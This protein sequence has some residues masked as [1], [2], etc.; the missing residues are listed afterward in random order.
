MKRPIICCILVILTGQSWCS[1]EAAVTIYQ[2]K[3]EVAFAILAGGRSNRMGSNKA[4]LVLK[5]RRFVDI[6]IDKAKEAGFQS[7]SVSGHD[8]QNKEVDFVSDQ[9]TDRGPLG[10][11]HAV[12]KQCNQEMSF[13]ISVDVP[14]IQCRT[15]RDIVE[16]HKKS[17]CPVTL[18]RHNEKVEPLIGV[19]NRHVYEE[20]ER[21]I[22][23]GGA[24]VFRALDKTG[25]GCWD[26]TGDPKTILNVNTEKDFRQLAG[27]AAKYL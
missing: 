18:L 7:I 4:E 20:I 12:L 17:S 21:L 9:F 1:G 16:A 24:P 13:I 15:I 8:P 27:E 25:Y 6:L 3:Q 14:F 2:P 5:G 19:Y 11:I 22:M 10:G 23:V 26:F